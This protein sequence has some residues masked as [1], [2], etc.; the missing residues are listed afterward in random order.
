M[1]KC[2]LVNLLQH[3]LNCDVTL[4]FPVLILWQ[5]WTRVRLWWRPAA[6]HSHSP[7]TDASSNRFGTKTIKCFQRQNDVEGAEGF[8]LR[9]V[10]QIH[11]VTFRLQFST[12][13][14]VKHG[15]RRD[16]ESLRQQSDWIQ[17]IDHFQLS[18]T[19][20]EFWHFVSLK[21]IWDFFSSVSWDET[22]KSTQLQV[23]RT[24]TPRFQLKLHFRVF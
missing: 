3:E 2:L 18:Q 23:L 16:S 15:I 12:W 19:N 20:S 7:P 11:P 10:W 6:L 13:T 14:V 4:V 24:F 9:D 17:L 8:T 21:T 1:E 5:I 22:V